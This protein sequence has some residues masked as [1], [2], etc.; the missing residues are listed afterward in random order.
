MNNHWLKK[1]DT[2]EID[3]FWRDEI[4]EIDKQIIDDLRAELD[5]RH[6]FLFK[7]DQHVQ[8]EIEDITVTGK[9]AG[10]YR[11]AE[12]GWIN[13]YSVKLDKDFYGFSKMDFSEIRLKNC[14]E[15]NIIPQYRPGDEKRFEYNFKVKTTESPD[16]IL[17]PDTYCPQKQLDIKLNVSYDGQH[18]GR[19][20]GKEWIDRSYDRM[21]EEIMGDI[22]SQVEAFVR[23]VNPLSVHA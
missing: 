12:G 17:N 5:R 1:N 22:K 21:V 13:Y 14:W 4:K 6:P 16:V 2:A 15:S 11:T 18:D 20:W 10:C 23:K 9:V 3:D 19:P 7:L 8:I